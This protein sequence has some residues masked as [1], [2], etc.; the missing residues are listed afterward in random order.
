MAV[1]GSLIFNTKIDASGFDK[2]VKELSSKTV[3]L[4][5]KISSTEA[6]IKNLK[7]ELQQTGNVKVKTKVSEGLE[8]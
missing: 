6:A 3:D 7:A 5:N 2:G 8:G 4:K 1:D